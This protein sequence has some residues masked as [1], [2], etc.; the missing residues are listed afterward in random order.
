MSMA[1]FKL[2]TGDVS[3]T[4][5]TFYRKSGYGRC[6]DVYE[7]NEWADLDSSA[8]STHGKYNVQS[9]TVD[10]EHYEVNI[11]ALRSC[12]LEFREFGIWC[13]HN[14]DIVAS[15]KKPDLWDAVLVE[16]LWGYGA[17]EVLADLSGNNLRKLVAQARSAL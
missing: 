7:V 9:G 4:P 6:F 16:C 14:G 10:L 15:T 8:I 2:L 1:R 11:A 17:K 13:P 12:G 3:G 5:A